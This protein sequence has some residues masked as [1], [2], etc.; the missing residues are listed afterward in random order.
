MHEKTPSLSSNA[1]LSLCSKVFAIH[2][3]NAIDADHRS[4]RKYLLTMSWYVFRV[5]H[6]VRFLCI[7]NLRSEK[8]AIKTT[9]RNE[10]N[11]YMRRKNLENIKIFRWI[12]NNIAFCNFSMEQMMDQLVKSFT[13]TYNLFYII[14]VFISIIGFLR[15][16]Q[17]LTNCI[18]RACLIISLLCL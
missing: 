16:R 17:Y 1:P 2:S 8:K 4:S 13:E 11:M 7:Q 18:M 15:R 14:F 10:K 3:A 6:P 9:F 5:P 12:H